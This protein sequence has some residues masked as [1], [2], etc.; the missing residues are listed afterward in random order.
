MRRARTMLQG[1]RNFIMKGNV[2]DMAVGV[3]IGVAFGNVVNALVKDIVTPLIGAFGGTPDFSGISFTINNSKFLIGD[4]INALVSFLT[5]SGVIYFTVV[6][7]MNKLLEKV[8]N[9]KSQDPTDKSCPECLSI[10]PIK[11]KRCK[12]CTAKFVK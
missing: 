9:G 12:Y 3:V 2:V 10:I 1:F 8:K 6:M 7:P 5:V 11:A 4:F